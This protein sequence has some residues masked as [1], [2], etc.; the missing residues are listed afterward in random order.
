M[1]WRR[2]F[3]NIYNQARA[4]T[5][6]DSLFTLPQPKITIVSVSLLEPALIIT[7][8]RSTISLTLI[9]DCPLFKNESIEMA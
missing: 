3:V 8:L 6:F 2:R 7:G 5:N 1:L 4:S 9:C